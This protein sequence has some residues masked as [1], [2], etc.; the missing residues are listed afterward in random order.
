MGIDVDGKTGEVRVLANGPQVWVAGHGVSTVLYA[1]MASHLITWISVALF[2]LYGIISSEL[3]ARPSSKEVKTPMGTTLVLWS[4]Y[5]AFDRPGA[6][7]IRIPKTI[8]HDEWDYPDVPAVLAAV[9]RTVAK[10]AGGTGY[11]PPE[12]DTVYFPLFEPFVAEA[13]TDSNSWQAY[14]RQRKADAAF[15]APG[16]LRM[17]IPD[18]RTTS[19]LYY[20]GANTKIPVVRPRPRI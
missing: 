6:W 3:S 10:E 2:P 19:G 15:R 14:L 16:G 13:S 5:E 18:G 9:P 8:W 12:D 4:P 1:D 20:R 11:N 17:T 7:W